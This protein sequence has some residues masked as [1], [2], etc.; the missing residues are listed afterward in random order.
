MKI[1][2]AWTLQE[3]NVSTLEA[4][5]LT[6]IVPISKVGQFTEGFC[7]PKDMGEL[8][9]VIPPSNARTN[10]EKGTALVRNVFVPSKECASKIQRII[11]QSKDEYRYLTVTRTMSNIKFKTVIVE[12]KGPNARLCPLAGRMHSTIRVWFLLQLKQRMVCIRCYHPVCS[13]STN[14]IEFPIDID[15]CQWLLQTLGMTTT[16]AKPI[17]EKPRESSTMSHIKR[18]KTS[19]PS[20]MQDILRASTE[21]TLKVIHPCL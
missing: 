3:M 13:K 10:G 7:P 8:A 5:L 12:V 4:L 2:V 14:K 9:D 1:Q 17:L 6:T 20:G 18:V 11:N 19:D 21:E 15:T 16:P